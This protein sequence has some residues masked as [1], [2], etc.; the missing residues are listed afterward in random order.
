MPTIWDRLKAKGRTG[1]YYFSDVPFLALWGTKY[2]SIAKPFAS[3]LTDAASR[4]TAGRLVR[5]PAVRGR[6]SGSSADD[7]PHADIRAG[8]AFLNQVYTAVTT[9]AKWANTLLVIN[10]DEWG[11]FYD[12]VAPGIAPDAHPW[13]ARRGFRVPAIVI[14][15]HAKARTSTTRCSTTPRSCVRSSGGSGSNH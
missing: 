8:E 9:G 15:P 2:L 11:G 7:H 10:Y 12:H 6:G 1:T 5:R 3:F 4:T 13:T 14:S